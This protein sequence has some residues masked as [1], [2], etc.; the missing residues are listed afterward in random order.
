MRLVFLVTAGPR[1]TRAFCE[2]SIALHEIDVFH[3]RAHDFCARVLR[4]E[5]TPLTLHGHD[6]GKLRH[7]ALE[8][9]RALRRHRLTEGTLDTW[10]AIEGECRCHLA[11]VC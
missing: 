7:Q 4:L 3:R 9:L 10:S 5:S 2:S 1:L 8:E 6:V 11:S